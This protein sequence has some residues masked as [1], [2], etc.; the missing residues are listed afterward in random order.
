MHTAENTVPSLSQRKERARRGSAALSPWREGCE[1]AR[2]VGLLAPGF[3]LD[4]GLPTVGC[5]GSDPTLSVADGGERT[6][7]SGASASALHRFPWLGTRAR[8]TT[9]VPGFDCRPYYSRE[10]PVASSKALRHSR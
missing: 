6:G 3:A 5:D 2:E 1:L 4:L 10:A 8:A 7:Y 9:R